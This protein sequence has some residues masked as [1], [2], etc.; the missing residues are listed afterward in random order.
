MPFR[1]QTPKASSAAVNKGDTNMQ[2]NSSI[3]GGDSPNLYKLGQNIK[4]KL[5]NLQADLNNLFFSG[6]LFKELQLY[7][8]S[9]HPGSIQAYANISV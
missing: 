2:I 8:S 9:L 4:V 1:H 5:A 3:P 7:F 6:K